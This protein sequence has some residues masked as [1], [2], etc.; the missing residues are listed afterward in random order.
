[1]SPEQVNG[2]EVDERSDLFALG[3]IC[4]EL[5]TKQRPITGQSLPHIFKAISEYKLSECPTYFDSQRWSHINKAIAQDPNER[6][7]TV[8]E[9]VETF[10]NRSLPNRPINKAL[11]SHPNAHSPSLDITLF[12]ERMEQV[13]DEQHSSE[14]SEHNEHTVNVDRTLDTDQTLNISPKLNTDPPM[15]TYRDSGQALFC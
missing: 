2:E 9:W 6:M 8:S 4:I 11:M 13:S 12:D 14:P 7:N 10:V 1:M 5:I 15:Q 3:L